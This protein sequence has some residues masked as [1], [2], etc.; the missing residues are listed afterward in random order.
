MGRIL[1]VGPGR[2]TGF[3]IVTLGALNILSALAGS[4]YPRLRNL[5]A[6]VPDAVAAP[7]RPPRVAETEAKP[8]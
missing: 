8:P 6:E 2:G 5:D 3:L 4:L 7:V 1:G